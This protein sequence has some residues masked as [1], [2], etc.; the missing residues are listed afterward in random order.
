M[1]KEL[2][3]SAGSSLVLTE[4]LL[5]DADFVFEDYGAYEVVCNGPETSS[6]L[7]SPNATTSIIISSE[8]PKATTSMISSE[9]PKATTSIISSESAKTTTSIISSGSAK[10]TTSVISS[11][12]PLSRALRLAA[13]DYVFEDIDG[14]EAL[15]NVP[16]IS[17]TPK[18][19][20]SKI[21]ESTHIQSKE[22]L[23]DADCGFKDNGACEAVFSGP[24]ASST[25]STKT[26][27]ASESPLAKVVLGE[28]LGFTSPFRKALIWPPELADKKK[29]RLKITPSNATADEWIEYYKRKTLEKEKKA[30]DIEKKKKLRQEKMAEAERNKK[31]KL[32]KKGSRSKGKSNVSVSK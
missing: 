25:P 18:A 13:D 6:T 19:T 16:E 31:I 27:K 28:K 1:A 11:E 2:A 20:T 22:R 12:S 32:Q 21:S 29:K 14:Y 9:S 4:E 10:T 5:A 26:S 30:A 3:G 23:V 17:S 24:I 8:S 7:Q 15:F